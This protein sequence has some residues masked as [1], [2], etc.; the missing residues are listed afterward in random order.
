MANLAKDQYKK[1]NEA[2]IREQRLKEMRDR[3]AKKK[4]DVAKKALEEERDKRLKELEKEVNTPDDV[5]DSI[6]IT[7]K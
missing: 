1:D 4:A 7:K 2:I 3:R 5:F 6:G